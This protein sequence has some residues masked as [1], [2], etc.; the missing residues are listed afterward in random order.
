MWGILGKWGIGHLIRAF[1]LRG[2]LQYQKYVSTLQRGVWIPTCG[3]KV[4][5]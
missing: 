4:K 3:I 5:E 1:K 2:I